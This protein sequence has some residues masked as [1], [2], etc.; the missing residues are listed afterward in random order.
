[1]KKNSNV[2][3][4]SKITKLIILISTIVL[5][6]ALVLVLLFVLMRRR[7]SAEIIT[8][9]YANWNLGQNHDNALELRMI[10][11]FMDEHPHI[12]VEIDT[13]IGAPMAWTDSLAL[14]ANQNRL[15]DVFGLEDISSKAAQGWLL[16]ITSHVWADVDFFDLTGNVQEVMR[17]YGTMYAVPFAQNIHGYFV[18]HDMLREIGLEPPSH[19][20]SANDFIS[21]VRAATDFNRPSI[22]LNTIFPFVEWFPSTLNPALG[23][24]GFNDLDISFALNSPEMLEAVRIAAELHSGGYVF[25]GITNTS[26]FPSG[27]ALGAFR[28]GQMAFFYGGSWHADIMLNQM[29]F[30]WEFIGVPG[31]RSIITLEVLGLASTTN[32][33]EEAYKL[34]RW[35]GHGTEGSLR[36][37]EYAR[38]M[39]I[40]PTTLPV[41]QN[42]AVLEELIQLVPIPGLMEIYSSLDNA[43]IDG[44]RVL[45]GYMQARFTAPTG[46]EV[47]GSHFVDIGVDALIR[48]A[49]TGHTYFPE[50]SHIAED[51]TR[52]Q[53]NSALIPFR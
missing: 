14:A 22:G 16:D 13:S 33:P 34:A 3:G 18:N 32:H 19:G 36:R 30:D 46:V 5:I 42:S 11:S 38:Q 50:N 12:R 40:M 6:L 21:M 17:I 29:N 31:G 35:M 24:F 8:L 2:K 9:T 51:I 27:N 52:Q 23:F 7:E 41:S 53:L 37:L 1:M 47:Y 39:G 20:M 49:I 10:Q 44:L 26:Y 25:D 45:P 28:D 48:Y 4:I 43:L 15:P